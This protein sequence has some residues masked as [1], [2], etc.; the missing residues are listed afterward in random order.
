MSNKYRITK[1]EC[2]KTIKGV[3]EGCGC[4]T[5]PQDLSFDL[6]P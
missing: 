6:H 3:C 5:D 2:E 1:E 4:A